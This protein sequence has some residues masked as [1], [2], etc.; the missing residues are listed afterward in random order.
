MSF[1]RWRLPGLFALL[2]LAGCATLNDPLTLND[3]TIPQVSERHFDKETTGKNTH[4]LFVC[5]T[6]SGGG[7]RAAALSYGVLEK[8][9]NTEIIWKG[10]K[11]TL[12][13]EVDC[14]SSVSGGSFTSA[15]YGL[16]GDRIFTDY[17]AQFLEQNVQRALFLRMLNPVNWFRLAS[18]HFSRSDL[19]AE[20]Y[21]NTV[22][23]HQPFAALAQSEQ[24]F[25]IINATNLANGE[26]FSFTQ[27]QFDFL[28]SDLN[29]YPVARAVAA[30]S[31]FPLLLSPITLRNYPNA[32]DYR[33]PKKVEG[34]LEDYE[35]NRR[36]Y[37]WARN[38]AMYVTEK[39]ALPYLHLMDGGLADNIGLRP[40]ESAFR[41]GFIR[42]K[43]GNNEIER[44]VILV[45][46]A[47]TQSADKISQR[48][49]PPGILYVAN[50][51]ATVAM[52]NYSTESV[53]VMR[54]LEIARKQT[55]DTFDKWSKT[56]GESG[57]ALKRELASGKLVPTMID[58]SFEALSEATPDEKARKQYFLELPTNFKLSKEQVNNLINIGPELLDLSPDFRALLESLAVTLPAAAP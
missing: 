42:K 24:P 50:A 44:L 57:D 35:D 10:K 37:Y 43:M 21:D 55:Q 12:L 53:E 3:P 48:Q 11:K 4:S 25:I 49:K 38:R 47:R 30:S 2:V 26:R 15:Y 45:V 1:K 32:A 33:L 20:Y 31:A 5:L 52:D 14:I 22:F 41:S 6:F 27:E 39:D 51:T 18:P 23:D 13:D 54:D 8:L 9:R 7:T 36:R 17:R 40:V 16:F 46:N 56:L 28:A 58:V 29:P 34:A 19:A